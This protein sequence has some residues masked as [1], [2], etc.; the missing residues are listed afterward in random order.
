M[1]SSANSKIVLGLVQGVYKWPMPVFK[2]LRGKLSKAYIAEKE[3]SF[4]ITFQTYEHF[5]TESK[6]DV[7]RGMHFQMEP[8]A[9]AKVI[10][11]VRGNA[12]ILLLDA[13][14][15][16]PTYGFLQK[17]SF[18]G[19]APLSIYI[20]AG[21]ALGYLILQDE[22][23]ISYRMDSGFCQN[24]D[25]GIDPSVISEYIPLPLA[26]TIRSDRDLDLQPFSNPKFFSSCS[27]IN[28]S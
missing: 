1:T 12:I 28:E 17:E 13:R 9:V 15:N 26:Q 7:F 25:A 4:P 14:R 2:D 20:P 22:T 21:V 18:S 19:D 8:H 11:Y 16:S 24:C 10:S 23:T 6:K 27:K 5:F 3:G